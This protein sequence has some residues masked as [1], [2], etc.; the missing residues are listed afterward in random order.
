MIRNANMTT[1]NARHGKRTQ[2]NP[3]LIGTARRPCPTQVRLLAIVF[4]A[5]VLLIWPV[6]AQNPQRLP[7]LP[8]ATR[9]PSALVFS[10][11]GNTLF[12]A[13]QDAGTV[14]VIDPESGKTLAGIA[15]G[16]QQP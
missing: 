16:G 2:Q 14:D 12:V 5:I 13:E 6:S 3:N 8:P 4:P 11:D 7:L 1:A 15:C 10:P 9:A